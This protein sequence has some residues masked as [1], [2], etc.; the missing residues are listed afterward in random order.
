MAEHEGLSYLH[1]IVP[2]RGSSWDFLEAGILMPCPRR[3]SSPLVTK[4]G[5]VFLVWEVMENF[6]V[7]FS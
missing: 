2:K 7:L 6:A 1:T 4:P 5:S 3:I